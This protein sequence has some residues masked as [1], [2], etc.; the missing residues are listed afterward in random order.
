MKARRLPRWWPP[1]LAGGLGL[2]L[3]A[4]GSALVL[5][6]PTAAA[7]DLGQPRPVVAGAAAP[8]S[9]QA[10]SQP[11]A[12]SQAAVA[13]PAEVPVRTVP[14]PVPTHVELPAESVSAPVV[15]IGVRPGGDLDLPDNPRT[16]GWWS[17][18][19]APGSTSGTGVLAGHI[20]SA[21]AG[22][23]TFAALLQVHVGDPVVITRADGSTVT[24]RV[25]SRTTYLKSDLPG[26]VFN[27]ALPDGL[28][29]I[30][31]GGP[32]DARTHHYQDNIVVRA[33]LA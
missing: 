20:D 10:S 11:A 5:A 16:V 21:T 19:L 2:G 25:A 26:T 7:P 32:Y 23:G 27:T 12:S 24:Y 33:T 18:S 17:G 29:M 14:T 1:A 22:L 13:P 30:T 9:P 15:P 8:A 6:G 31:C 4:A 3:T 28:T